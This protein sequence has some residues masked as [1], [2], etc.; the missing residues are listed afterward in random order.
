MNDFPGSD[1][2]LEQWK[3]DYNRDGTGSVESLRRLAHM[4][5]FLANYELR[6]ADAHLVL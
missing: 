1:D 5:R 4:S 3:E 6:S 2:A